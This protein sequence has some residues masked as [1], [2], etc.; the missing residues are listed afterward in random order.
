MRKPKKD[1]YLKVVA[2]TREYRRYLTAI[3]RILVGVFFLTIGIQKLMD[4]VY[5]AG[6]IEALKIP[7]PTTFAILGGII[8]TVAGAALVSGYKSRFA[9]I[10]LIAYTLI[11]TIIFHRPGVWGD[12]P[13]GQIMLMKNLAIIGGLIFMLPN[14]RK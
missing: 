10:T 2:L 14:L 3:G 1:L 6:Y 8:T 12:D 5:V 7:F 13:T 9:A 4:I 11:I